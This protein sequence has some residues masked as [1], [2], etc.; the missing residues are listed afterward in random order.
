MTYLRDARRIIPKIYRHFGEFQA[1][2][3]TGTAFANDDLFVHESA[4]AR[5]PASRS[6]QVN[7]GE[8]NRVSPTNFSAI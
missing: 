7:A 8:S 4:T 1:E 6:D 5:T 3:R 2:L